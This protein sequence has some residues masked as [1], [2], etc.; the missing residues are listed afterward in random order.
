M[1]ILTDYYCNSYDACGAYGD[2]YDTISKH[3]DERNTKPWLKKWVKYGKAPIKRF[4]AKL[5]KTIRNL[6]FFC[7]NFIK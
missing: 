4:I 2:L 3:G 7:Q 6:I 5:I 1:E